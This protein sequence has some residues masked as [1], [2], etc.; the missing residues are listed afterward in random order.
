M[1]LDVVFLSDVD[2]SVIKIVQNQLNGAYLIAITSYSIF[3]NL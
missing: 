1:Y 3:E 2:D